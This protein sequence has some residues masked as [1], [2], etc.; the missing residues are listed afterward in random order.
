MASKI[1]GERSMR[2]RP[3]EIDVPSNRFRLLGLAAG[4]DI[5]SAGQN[6]PPAAR[7]GGGPRRQ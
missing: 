1:A 2:F 6:T 4:R 3:P 5:V 7:C